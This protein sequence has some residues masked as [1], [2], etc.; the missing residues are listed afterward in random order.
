M[1][2]QFYCRSRWSR[3]YCR[4]LCDEMQPYICVHFTL[5]TCL[6]NHSTDLGQWVWPLFFLSSLLSL[7]SL[8]C[9][10]LCD[11]M[12]PYI[13]VHFT[14]FT[15]LSNHSTDLGQWVWPLFFLSSLLS[16][17]CKSLCSYW[18]VNVRVNSSGC[19]R[20]LRGG[21]DHRRVKT[22]HTDTA[23]S[24]CEY[25]STVASPKCVIY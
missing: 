6:S 9:R 13:C 23:S 17:I 1:W 3:L 20:V 5:F 7:H 21:N 4:F 16:L 11:E 2:H 10:F 14:L 18:G 8:Y 15:C 22:N 19:R 12:Q 25:I 24:D